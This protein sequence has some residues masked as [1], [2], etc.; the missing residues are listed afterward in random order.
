M[1]TL[2]EVQAALRIEDLGGLQLGGC[3]WLSCT[4]TGGA[5]VNNKMQV[6]FV[7]SLQ[8]QVDD[9]RPILLMSPRFL[10]SQCNADHD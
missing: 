10:I 5:V 2:R 6:A 9:N 3:N 4:A 8:Q 7:R 1:G